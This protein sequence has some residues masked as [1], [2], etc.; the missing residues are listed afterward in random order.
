M[1]EDEPAFVKHQGLGLT[2]SVPHD[3]EDPTKHP[4]VLPFV[5]QIGNYLVHRLADDRRATQARAIDMQALR[6]FATSAVEEIERQYSREFDFEPAHNMAMLGRRHG[7]K[8]SR[9][10]VG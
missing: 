5:Q 7:D 9:V 6:Q 3:H 4:R 2:Y 10:A 1:G 8:F